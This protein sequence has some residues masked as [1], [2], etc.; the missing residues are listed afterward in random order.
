MG[1]TAGRSPERTRRALL[2]AAA[3]CIRA[4]GVGAPLERVAAAAGV[5][6]GGLLYHFPTKD[7]L[8]V[9]L[10]EDFC[11]GFRAA[12]V[13]AVDPDDHAPG[14]LLRGYVRASFELPPDEV[15]SRETMALVA[16]LVTHP[17][18]ARIARSDAD[19]WAA[20]LDA[21]GVPPDLVTLVVAAA[22]GA[23]MAPMWGAPLPAD[24]HRELR[25]RLLRLTGP[26]PGGTS[27]V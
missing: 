8:L 14:R 5:S 2:D 19:R 22:D 23:S 13:A 26:A 6:K 11:D 21:D 12:V 16:Q 27:A 17:V 9:A 4:Q 3:A 25:D 7:A 10:V 15:G 1:R 18:A 20:D 24:R